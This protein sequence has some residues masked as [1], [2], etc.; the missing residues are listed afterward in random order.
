[1]IQAWELT[2]AAC[3]T[4][5]VAVVRELYAYFLDRATNIDVIYDGTWKSGVANPTS[6][7]GLLWSSKAYL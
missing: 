7:L 5:R 2:A 3:E 4:E 6:V 1:M